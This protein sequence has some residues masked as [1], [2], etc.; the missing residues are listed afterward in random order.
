MGANPNQDIGEVLMRIDPVARAGLDQRVQDRRIVAAL[1]TAGEQPVLAF[2]L[3][4]T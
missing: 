3:S 4:S 2:M 1:L